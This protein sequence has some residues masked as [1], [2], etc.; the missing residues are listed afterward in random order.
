MQDAE[1]KTLSLDQLREGVFSK[2]TK[3]VT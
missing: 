1:V 2:F 3:D